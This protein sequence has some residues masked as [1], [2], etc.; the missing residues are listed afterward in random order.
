MNAGDDTHIES[1]FKR[2]VM[3]VDSLASTGQ[4]S[5]AISTIRNA[6]AIHPK[7]IFIIALEKQLEKLLA[8]TY[9]PTLADPER[10]KEILGSIPTLT[11]RAVEAMNN[12]GPVP[13]SLPTHHSKERDVAFKKLKE[14][15]FRLA[16]GHM[17]RSEYQSALE[18]IRRV[19]I[20]DPDDHM[21]K[22]Y[23]KKAK[24]LIDLKDNS[25]PVTTS[26]TLQEKQPRLHTQPVAPLQEKVV[27]QTKQPVRKGRRENVTEEK[28]QNQR[29]VEGMSPLSRILLAVGIPVFLVALVLAYLIVMTDSKDPAPAINS[30][31]VK[32]FAPSK[33]TEPIA[34]KTESEQI[35]PRVLPDSQASSNVNGVQLPKLVPPDAKPAAVSGS[36]ASKGISLPV[37]RASA[38]STKPANAGSQA[39]RS[40]EASKASAELQPALTTNPKVVELVQK[41]DPKALDLKAPP[42]AKL[43]GTSATPTGTL[44]TEA[45][46]RITYGQRMPEVIRLVNPKYPTEA[47]NAGIEGEVVV[48]VQI[49]PNGKPIQAKIVKSSSELFN[50]V[51]IDAA[52][53]SQY[54]PGIMPTGPV[55][56]WLRLPFTFKRKAN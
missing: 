30:P 29:R 55:K 34:A 38:P 15:Y 21:A 52:L 26:P 25:I 19:L 48:R 33:N 28:A 14:Q 22:E 23:Q 40:I 35:A 39:K 27:P 13:T 10:Q 12:E 16:D 53:K 50:D 31:V 5:K 11:Q 54:S 3:E 2:Q 24:E 6:K 41:R 32:K 51:V 9:S 37:T 8:F 49:D 7:N 44:K 4:Y 18:E 36:R 17:Q 42:P 45:P 43:E 1:L 46:A 47:W 56:T 20:L